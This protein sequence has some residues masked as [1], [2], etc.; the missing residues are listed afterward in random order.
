MKRTLLTLT[1]AAALSACNM[2]PTY[3]RPSP[4]IPATFPAD[5]AYPSATATE[6]PGLPWTALISDPRLKAVIERALA[7]NR[8]LRAAL[9]NVEAARA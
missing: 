1:S 5:A 4:P 6:R 2:A 7:N 9:A 3:V 8:D